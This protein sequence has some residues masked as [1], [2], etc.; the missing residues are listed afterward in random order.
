MISYGQLVNDF[1]RLTENK[2]LSHAYI[3]FGEEKNNQ[4]KKFSFAQSLANFL[5]TGIFESPLRLLRDLL[6]ISPDEKGTIGIDN[7]RLL[8][9][10]LWQNPT[11][12]RRRTAIIRNAKNLT[13]EA[14]NAAL[15]IVEEPPESSLI[16]FVANHENDLFSVLSSRLQKIYFPKSSDLQKE[17]KDKRKKLPKEINSK[18]IDEITENIDY[19]FESLINNLKKDPIKNVEQLKETLKRLALIKQFNTN[20]KLQLKALRTL[21]KF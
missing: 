12:S 20:K 13:S 4:E 18:N 19:F 6:I 5:E 9:N 3:F 10:F 2:R 15:K 7:I 14:Q 8:K 16:I 1:K 17:E 21:E 11:N